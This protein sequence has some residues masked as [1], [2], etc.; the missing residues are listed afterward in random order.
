VTVKRSGREAPWAELPPARTRFALE[1]TFLILV[2]VAAVV[3]RLSP[4]SIIALM[5]VACLLVAVIERASYQRQTRALARVEETQI[6]PLTA[7]EPPATETD[8]PGRPPLVEAEIVVSEIVVEAIPP[9]GPAVPGLDAAPPLPEPVRASP[10]AREWNIWDLERRARQQA[11][12]PLRDEK[13]AAL[14]LHLRQFANADG[15]LPMQFDD[16]VRESFSEL[17]QA[18]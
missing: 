2:A 16:L 3:A 13:W 6:P 15:V 11:G 18:A 4:W 14:F 9:P 8:E 12:D 7:A 1:A 17:I 5:L 10:P